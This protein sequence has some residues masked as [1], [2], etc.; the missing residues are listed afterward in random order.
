MVDDDDIALFL[1]STVLGDNFQNLQIE[2]FN[3]A[4]LALA[5]LDGCIPSTTEYLIFLD[6]NMPVMNGWQF[7]DALSE[8]PSRKN[9]RVVMVTSSIE[10]AEKEKAL[11]TPLVEGFIIKPF[12]PEHID[13]LKALAGLNPF[14]SG[15]D[16]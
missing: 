2:T 8:H 3:T 15:N 4:G 9:T 13:Q 14:F 12:Q 7:L 11:K 1:H 5:Y 16:K 10:V 6:I